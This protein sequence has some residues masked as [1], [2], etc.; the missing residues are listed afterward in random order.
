VV[1]GLAWTAV[2]GDVLKIEAVKIRGKGMMALTGS[3]GEVMKESAKIAQTVVKVLIDGKR[4]AIDP[5]LIPVL[6]QEK[7]HKTEPSASEIYHR[8]D[9]HLHIPEGA[10]PKDGPS[11]GITM[12]CAIASILSDKKVHANVAM[13]GELTLSGKVLPIGG[14][15]EKLIAAH[16][17]KMKKVLIPQKNYDRDLDEI[18]DEVKENLEIVAVNTIDEVLRHVLV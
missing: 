13:T 11:A 12:A 3:L 17:A 16:K 1:N 6:P 18:P 14:L 10:T 15:K 4:L 2:G 7:E 5:G 8:Y 9:L